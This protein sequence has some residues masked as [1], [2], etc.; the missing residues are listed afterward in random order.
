MSDELRRT[1]SGL[2][3]EDGMALSGMD[4]EELWVR[5][6]GVGGEIGSLEIEAYVLGVLTP[7][8]YRHNLIAQAMNEHFLDLGEDHPVAYKDSE[9]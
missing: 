2:S 7:D 6:V 9:L 8:A 3:L 1:S 5:Q 4:Y